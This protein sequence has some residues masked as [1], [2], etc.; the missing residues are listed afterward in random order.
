MTNNR[1]TKMTEQEALKQVIRDQVV[2]QVNTMSLIE[3]SLV[4]IKSSVAHLETLNKALNA[5]YNELLDMSDDIG[6][7]W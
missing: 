4:K 3:D 5:R 2:L 1:G 7:E 6:L